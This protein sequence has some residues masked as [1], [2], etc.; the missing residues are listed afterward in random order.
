MAPKHKDCI[1]AVGEVH[2]F[3][4]TCKEQEV[5]LAFVRTNHSPHLLRHELF[6]LI[7]DK[8]GL[9]KA[10]YWHKLLQAVRKSR[11]AAT[12]A[13][14]SVMTALHQAGALK[15]HT[16]Q[17]VLVTLSQA[18]AALVRI[19]APADVMAQLRQGVLQEPEVGAA[20]APDQLGDGSEPA[21]DPNSLHLADKL[22][23][24]LPKQF[25]AITRGQCLGLKNHPAALNHPELKL[26][27]ASFRAFFH[28]LINL[29]RGSKCIGQRS[30]DTVCNDLL[31]ILGF[32]HTHLGIPSPNLY[33]LVHAE[34]IALWVASRMAAGLGQGSLTHDIHALTKV[35]QF[36]LGQEGVSPVAEQLQK[37]QTWLGTL[38][39]QVGD[40]VHPTKKDPHSMEAQGKWV[41]AETLVQCFEDARLQSIHMVQQWQADTGS[42]TAPLCLPMAQYL[43]D[44]L[45]ANLLFGYLPPQR[46]ECV[47]TMTLPGVEQACQESVCGLGP[48]CKGN[49]LERTERGYRLVFPHHKNLRTWK[50]P[51]IVDPLPAELADLFTMYFEFALP[52]L[53][54]H[55]PKAQQHGRVFFTRTGLVHRDSMATFWH[56]VMHRLGLPVSVKMSPQTMRHIFVGERTGPDAK[57]GPSDAAASQLMGNSVRAWERYYNLAN[58]DG[59][60]AQE[61]IEQMQ[62]WRAAMLQKAGAAAAQPAAADSTL[63]AAELAMP[64]APM[65]ME[66]EEVDVDIV[67]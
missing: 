49:R 18:L 56:A 41:S 14:P 65:Q 27:M 48:E 59:K 24:F 2:S 20:E 26:Q 5:Q 40:A 60:T 32:F 50:K 37:L 62:P 25:P 9:C 7:V 53:H 19:R 34:S 54:Q 36:W 3:S 21:F 35:V 55:L 6:H 64:S 44:A 52:R 58:F 46:L 10:T 51:I 12:T 31:Y 63:P 61:A 66:T 67:G 28:E 8:L 33:H 45:L 42:T 30:V 4:L 13:G 11:L 22:P 15:A 47:K 39:L 29:S 17:V 23:Q 38:R 1:L 57:A 43:Q 16:G